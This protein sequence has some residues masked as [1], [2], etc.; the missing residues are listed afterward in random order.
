MKCRPGNVV[1]D[2]MRGQSLAAMTRAGRDATRVL[3]CAVIVTVPVLSAL[4]GAVTDDTF[5]GNVTVA[6]SER[7]V[8]S[9]EAIDTTLG[10]EPAGWFRTRV[11]AWPARSSAGV[12]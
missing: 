6:G 9:D 12:A 3:R 1:T 5:A 10:A 8:G 7:I 2:G 11:P 4:S